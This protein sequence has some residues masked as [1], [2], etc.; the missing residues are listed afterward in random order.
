MLYAEL[1][2]LLLL[3]YRLP[4]RALLLLAMLLVL[5]FP[6]GHLFGGDRDDDWPFEDA[7]EAGAWLMDE[8]AESPLVN[9][10]LSEV[11]A[12]HSSLSP[13]ASGP[14]GNIPIRAS[15]CWP[16]FLSAW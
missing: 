3:L 6:V 14:I 7:A 10:S 11:L 5:S 13:N 8:R 12:Y 15:W 16:A 2:L 9:G 4:S 1:G